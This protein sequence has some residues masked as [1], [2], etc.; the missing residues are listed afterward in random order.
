MDKNETKGDVRYERKDIRLGYLLVV[1]LAGGCA[2]ATV[3]YATWRFFR[4]HEGTP[5]LAAQPLDWSAPHS[6]AELPPEPRLEQ[7]DR[8]ARVQSIDVAK[9]LV[10]DE[11]LL[12]SYGPTEEKGF[13]RIPISEAIRAVAGKLPVRQ[14]SPGKG[15]NDGGLVDAG[16]PNSGRVFRGATP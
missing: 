5:E 7:V 14:P 3:G 16:E 8:L 12:Q 11:Q 9:R 4:W 1:M 13:V 10:A 2:L 6:S 15:A